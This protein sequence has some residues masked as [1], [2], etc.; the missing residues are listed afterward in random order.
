MTLKYVLKSL[1]RRKIRTILML[2]ALIVGVGALVAL[3]ATVDIFERF[4]ISIISNT[5]GDYDLVIQKN[6]IEPSLLIE[7][8]SLIPVI[9]ASDPQVK[10]IAPRIQGVVDVDA[11]SDEA[12]IIHGSAQFVALNRAEDTMGDFEVISGTL[13]FAPGY[14][15][16][17]Q[18]TADTFDL[19]PG[20]TFDISYGLPTPRQRGIESASNVSARQARTTLTVSAIA[21]QRGVTGLS[22]NDGVLIDLAYAQEWLNLPGLAERIVVG[23]DESVYG[24]NDPQAAAFQARALSEKV[25]TL[26]GESY[27]YTLPRAKILSDSFEIFIFFQALV[28][29]YGILSLSVVGLLVRTMV[30]TNVREQTRELALF[31]IIG[32]P[33]TYLFTLV[34]IEIGLMGI[35]GG[36]LGAIGGQT[37]T[38]TVIVPFIAQEANVPLADIPLASP[39]AIIISVAT[40][41]VMLIISA[42]PPAY[43]A[44]STKIMYAINPGVAEG[45]GLDDLAKMRER[46]FSYSS[47]WSGLVVILFPT[48]IFFIFPLAF[49]FG[50]IWLWTTLIFGSLLLMVVAISLILYPATLPI[51]RVLIRLIGLVAQRVGYFAERNIVRGQNRNG[52]IGLMIVISATLPVFFATTLALE[53]ANTETDT[54]LGNGAPLIVRKSGVVA[55]S[56]GDGPRSESVPDEVRNRFSSDLLEEIRSNPFLGPNVAVSYRFGTTIRD[57]VGLRDVGIRVYGL[58]G[59]LAPLTYDEGVEWIAGGPQSFDQL[60]ADPS[61][62]IVSE[63]LAEY[64]ERGVGDTLRLKGAG[65]DHERQVRIVGILGR[66]PGFNGFT[67]KRISAQDGRTDLFINEVAFRELTRDPLDGPY[68]SAYPIFERL[69]AA[70]DR[71]AG[72]LG[73]SSEVTNEAVSQVATDLRKEYG[74]NEGVWVRSTPEDIETAQTGAQQVRVVILVLTALSFVL[75]IFGVFVVTYIS[76][77]TRRS[78]I[79]MLKAMGDSNQHLFGMFLSEALVMTLSATITGIIAGVLLGYIFRISDGFTSETPT[80]FAFDELVTPYILTLMIVAATVSTLF[81]TWGYLRKQA[82]EILRMV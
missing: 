38:N 59:N 18:E 65:L 42:Y 12:G 60:L 80:V 1:S 4:N 13:N 35:I 6:E 51:E 10:I 75:A 62:V 58:D 79:A 71:R 47:F 15:V 11:V 26:L 36:S 44:S 52:L 17:L 50:I 70:P 40:A 2:L 28:S 55:F 49:T 16:I 45:L 24:D 37:L 9:Q 73:L 61:A 43:R 66:F 57:N 34:A 82:I 29:V 54:R 81:A 7:S 14:A 31:R 33:R 69:T 3:N 32:A 20:D 76:V 46:N 25:Q 56:E 30:G 63:G 64:F 8:Q 74:L 72:L 48:L 53:V 68:D 22:G 27:T 5:A 23:F 21:L 78:E 39:R 77:Y 41:A 67:S 19:Q